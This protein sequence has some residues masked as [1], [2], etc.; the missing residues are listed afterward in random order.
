[1]QLVI[2]GITYSFRNEGNTYAT[3]L[4]AKNYVRRW[5]NQARSGKTNCGKHLANDLNEPES[6]GQ[7]NPT[8][9][10]FH[11]PV[12][13]RESCGYGTWEVLQWSRPTPWQFW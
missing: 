11:Q 5:P 4:E 12:I 10:D 7:I 3:P 2:Y 8:L 6:S 13:Y 9:R 1:M